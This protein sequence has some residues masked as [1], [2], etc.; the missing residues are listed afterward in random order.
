MKESTT[1]AWVWILTGAVLGAFVMFLIKLA[2]VKPDTQNA[3]AE[4]DSGNVLDIPITFYDKLK[5]N[6]PIE[7]PDLSNKATEPKDT[8]PNTY[9]IQVASFKSAEDAE[10]LRAELIFLGLTETHVKPAVIAKNDVRH[11]VIIGP[12]TKKA[13]LE[14]ARKR[15]L[16][17]KFDAL[18]LKTAPQG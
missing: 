6:A 10:Q 2:E 4:R 3:P 14:G 8:K 16:D 1:P 9:L 5:E 7:L 17:N 12:F 13:E 15:L 11:R 18:V